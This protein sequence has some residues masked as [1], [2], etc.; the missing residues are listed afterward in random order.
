MQYN[1][2][3]QQIIRFGCVIAVL[4]GSR[5]NTRV[6][7]ASVFKAL[8]LIFL[9]AL[10]YEDRSHQTGVSPSIFANSGREITVASDVIVRECDV[11]DYGIGGICAAI[12]RKEGVPNEY[13]L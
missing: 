7:V 13:Q 8:W 6:E 12:S 5:W 3:V 11:L 2:G 10:T 9:Y 1:R 4:C